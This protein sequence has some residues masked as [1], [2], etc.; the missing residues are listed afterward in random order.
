MIKEHKHFVNTRDA[1]N[2]ETLLY[3]T[4]GRQEAAMLIKQ[5]TLHCLSQQWP[6]SLTNVCTTGSHYVHDIMHWTIEGYTIENK[7]LG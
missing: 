4:G 3:S 1:R 5:G 2:I 6:D 7:P